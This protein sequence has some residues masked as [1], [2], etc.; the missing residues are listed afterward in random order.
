MLAPCSSKLRLLALVALG[1]G[2]TACGFD[3]VAGPSQQA[4][5]IGEVGGG[6]G[7]EIGEIGGP[8]RPCLLL[9]ASPCR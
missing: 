8:G 7:D 4:E 2:L 6:G 3:R 9:R 5:P 1:G